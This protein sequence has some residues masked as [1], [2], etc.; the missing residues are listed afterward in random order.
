[1]QEKLGKSADFESSL[2]TDQCTDM[3]WTWGLVHLK[4]H[5]KLHLVSGGHIFLSGSWL[6][7]AGESRIPLSFMPSI[8]GRPLTSYKVRTQGCLHH[9]ILTLDLDF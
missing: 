4:E 1:V 6:L 9:G 2:L 5:I 7:G 3:L 8:S